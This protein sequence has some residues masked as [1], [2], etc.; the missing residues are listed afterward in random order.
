[1][2]VGG[3]GCSSGLGSVGHG[4][5]AGGEGSAVSTGAW[6]EGRGEAEVELER[7]RAVVG[8]EE[9]DVEDWRGD[10]V[11]DDFLFWRGGDVDE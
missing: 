4:R 6:M 7:N 10:D 5:T 9:D 2:E 3:D 8:D 11:E 1:M